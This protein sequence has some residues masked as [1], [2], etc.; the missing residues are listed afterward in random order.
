METF[1][2]EVNCVMLVLL[3]PSND[4]AVH[5]HIGKKSHRL[6]GR[7][8]LFLRQPSRIL[9]RLLDIFPFQVRVTFK[10]FV[11]TRAVSNLAD[12]D[13]NRNAHAAYARSPAHNLRIES[14]SLK[15]QPL[16]SQYSRGQA[17]ND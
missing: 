11:K 8:N 13:R 10:Y 12:D 1:I 3:Q 2:A 6:L 16:Q 9:D 4:P 7:V 15:H 5:T 14:D 17:P